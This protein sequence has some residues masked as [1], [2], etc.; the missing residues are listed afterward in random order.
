MADQQLGANEAKPRVYD[1][2][3]KAF[4]QEGV[5][6]CFALLGDANMNWAARL[7]EQGCRM[8]YVRHEHCALAS[9]SNSNRRNRRSE[10]TVAAPRIAIA[11]ESSPS[12]RRG[13]SERTR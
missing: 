13:S 10:S 7:A 6:T 4:A 5:T 12:R 1:V 9:A 3:A 2:L 11:S 8:I